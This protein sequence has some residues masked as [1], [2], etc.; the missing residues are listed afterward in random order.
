MIAKIC[1]DKDYR[2]QN[3]EFLFTVTLCK[4]SMFRLFRCS[5]QNRPKAAAV[6]NGNLVQ[7]VSLNCP[8][9]SSKED[10]S[11]NKDHKSISDSLKGMKTKVSNE[12][13]RTAFFSEGAQQ[14]PKRR[15]VLIIVTLILTTA[16]VQVPDD[17][18]ETNAYLKSIKEKKSDKDALKD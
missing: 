11:E 6:L 18:S 2:K 13:E 10:K 1:S 8:L 12:W 16:Y 14:I 9:L 7:S 17:L 5:P 15:V 3:N 4:I